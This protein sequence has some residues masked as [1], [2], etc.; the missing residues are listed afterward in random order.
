MSGTTDVARKA[1]PVIIRRTAGQVEI[2]AFR[3]PAA[4]CQLVKGTIEADE[5]VHRAAERELLEESGLFGRAIC[6]LGVVRMSE[7]AQ[8]WH[9]VLCEIPGRIPSQLPGEPPPGSGLPLHQAG[10]LPET[11]PESWT[12]HTTDGGGLDF[13][14]FWHPLH[15]APDDNWHPVFRRALAFIGACIPA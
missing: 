12:Y 1:C 7:P 9:F 6:D 14:F 2:L 3:H 15:H 8:D 11:L 10:P 4:G 13:A 5:P